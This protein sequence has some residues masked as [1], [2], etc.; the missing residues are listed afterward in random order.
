M[1][2]GEMY[3][4]PTASFSP[5]PQSGSPSRKQILLSGGPPWGFRTCGGRDTNIHLRIARTIERSQGEAETL[6][7]RRNSL[8]DKG[9]RKLQTY[10]SLR[11]LSD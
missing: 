8:N 11:N 10:Q 9:I 4:E 2:F 1:E 7:S 5:P 6:F 3:T